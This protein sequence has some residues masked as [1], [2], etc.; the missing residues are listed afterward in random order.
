MPKTTSRR[1]LCGPELV[2]RRASSRCGSTGFLWL[3][4]I[5]SFPVVR[6]RVRN[7]KSSVRVPSLCSTAWANGHLTSIKG[8]SSLNLECRRYHGERFWRLH[9]DD[10][11]ENDVSL[12]VLQLPEIRLEPE[13]G[14]TTTGIILS[15]TYNPMS[16]SRPLKT[17]AG[18][19]VRSFER[20]RLQAL[21]A[22]GQ[23]C[24][25]T[26]QQACTLT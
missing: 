22:A 9:Q 17:P 14:N 25:E 2:V 8:G 5:D 1:L 23:Q 15:R 26:E 7:S 16:D 18:R 10:D 4:A 20:S 19:V 6:P 12:M 13:R 21:T 3:R 24:V 11:D